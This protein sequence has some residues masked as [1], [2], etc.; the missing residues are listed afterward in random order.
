MKRIQREPVHTDQ[1]KEYSKPTSDDAQLERELD[2]LYADNVWENKNDNKKDHIQ[3][4]G[5][6]STDVLR[7][8]AVQ[9]LARED[10]RLPCGLQR[11]APAAPLSRGGCGWRGHLDLSVFGVELRS[12]FV[13]AEPTGVGLPRDVR[14]ADVRADDLA[15]CTR[16]LVDGLAHVQ[17]LGEPRPVQTAQAVA[18]LKTGVL[19]RADESV[20]CACPAE[21]KQ[22]AAGLQDSQGLVCPCFVPVLQLALVSA[23]VAV[24]LVV[25]S[26]LI[27]DGHPSDD[28]PLLP[29]L[30]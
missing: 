12:G 10:D 15:F 24:A 14:R 3:R 17:R 25:A 30:P 11:G 21:R 19:E 1:G 9:R 13:A 4:A 26:G 5:A 27:A 28:V 23:H 6:V 8:G 20:V 16:R 29:P 22:V 2:I 7:D 18:D